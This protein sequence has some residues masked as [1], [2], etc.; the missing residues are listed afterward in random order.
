MNLLILGG[1]FGVGLLGVIGLVALIV[2]E[3][4]PQADAHV[5]GASQADVAAEVQ[6][7][8]TSDAQEPS[9]AP[10]EVSEEVEPA[11]DVLTT[12]ASPIATPEH[13]LVLMNGQGHEFAAQLRTLHQ[14]AQELEQRLSV[15][16]AV[17]ER[18]EYSTST[19]SR[20]TINEEEYTLPRVASVR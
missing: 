7:Q 19:S 8:A 9:V 15:L 17:V 4:R 1:F 14:Q 11:A 18:F 16:V 5:Q 12:S 3:K 13:P 6:E 10:L 2:T 20:I